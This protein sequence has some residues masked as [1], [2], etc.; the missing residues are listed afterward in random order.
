MKKWIV[1]CLLVLGMLMAGCNGIPK[2]VDLGCCVSNIPVRR[3]PLLGANSVTVTTDEFI[4]T[5]NTDQKVY[6][7][8]DVIRIWGTLEYIGDSRTVQIWHA[9]PFMMFGIRGGKFDLEAFA[10]LIGT[11]STLQRGRV[12]HFEYQ[13]SG[14]WGANSPDAAFWEAFFREPDLILPAGTY[15]VTL[16]GDFTI[17][18]HEQRRQSGL[19]AELTFVVE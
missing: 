6:S 17:G 7:E 16:F 15:T 14:G 5:L 19:F 11:S 1:V 10:A 9:C 8:T 13:K 18:E 4:M 3:T 12:Y 2:T